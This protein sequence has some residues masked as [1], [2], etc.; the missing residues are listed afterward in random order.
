MRTELA[1]SKARI[2]ELEA[3]QARSEP[4]DK[5][6]DRSSL[7]ITQELPSADSQSTTVPAAGDNVVSLPPSGRLTPEEIK[8]RRRENGDV[9]E[10]RWQR[11]S[12]ADSVSLRG[13]GFGRFDHPGWK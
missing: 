11:S 5:S 10:S 2:A 1:A 3:A 8:A 6:D 9:L 13:D 7:S 4:T 12:F